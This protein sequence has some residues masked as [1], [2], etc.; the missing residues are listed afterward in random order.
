L[1][2]KLLKDRHCNTFQMAIIVF[3]LQKNVLAL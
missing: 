2:Q 1:S 3:E